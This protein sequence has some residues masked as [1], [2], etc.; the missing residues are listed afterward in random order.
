MD[1]GLISLSTPSEAVNLVLNTQ[2]LC[3]KDGFHVYK[4]MSNNKKFY[5][6]SCPVTWLKEFKS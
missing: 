6:L 4:F 3:K 2:A 5:D 1:D